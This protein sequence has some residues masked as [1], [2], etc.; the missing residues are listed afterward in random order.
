[1]PLTPRDRRA[2]GWLL[3]AALG[4]VLLYALGPVLTPFVLAAVLAYIFQPLS[5]SC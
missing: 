3:I 2:L 1:M 5:M 4:M